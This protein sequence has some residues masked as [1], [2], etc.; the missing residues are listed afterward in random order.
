MQPGPFE[1]KK[2]QGFWVIACLHITVSPDFVR[3][4]KPERL[5]PRVYEI[6][7]IAQNKW[8]QNCDLDVF[9]EES[10][11]VLG[12]FVEDPGQC[13]R[14]GLNGWYASLVVQIPVVSLV[15]AVW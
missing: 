15:D 2:G 3:N 9:I 11:R 8:A 14:R 7:A 4:L 1:S 13:S 5:P 10:G 12:L 6:Y